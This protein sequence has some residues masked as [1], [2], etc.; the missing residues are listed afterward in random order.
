M[1]LPLQVIESE[2]DSNTEG[3]LVYPAV[4]TEIESHIGLITSCF[5]AI[6]RIF[7]RPKVVRDA[8]SSVGLETEEEKGTPENGEAILSG[9]FCRR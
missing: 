7:Q 4:T 3:G 6:N 5:P 8:S 1:S 9:G 2:A